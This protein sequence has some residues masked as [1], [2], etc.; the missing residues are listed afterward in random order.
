MNFKT[1]FY[2]ISANF[3]ILTFDIRPHTL[4]AKISNLCKNFFF[5]DLSQIVRQLR[6]PP[7]LLE[8]QANH[9]HNAPQ[10]QLR[11]SQLSGDDE[12]LER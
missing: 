1:K 12:W 4:F 11:I 2:M 8:L 6:R 10:S 5:C 9:P 7:Q 3:D